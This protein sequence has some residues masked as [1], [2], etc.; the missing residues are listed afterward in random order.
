MHGRSIDLAGSR[1]TDGRR[2][3]WGG[4]WDVG[5]S[6]TYESGM[7]DP[8]AVASFEDVSPYGVYDM[9][10]NVTEWIDACQSVDA[11]TTPD[12]QVC[13]WSGYFYSWSLT[14]VDCSNATGGTDR[15]FAGCQVGI[16]CCTTP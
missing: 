8:Q 12:T 5:K 10:G 13:L 3:P 9:L 7:R 4:T 14:A 1:G 16:R 11:S 2:F 15:N 6:N